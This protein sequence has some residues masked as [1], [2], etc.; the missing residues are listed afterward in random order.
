ML[1]LNLSQGDF[2][3]FISCLIE[4]VPFGR[5]F[6]HE[7]RNRDPSR[8]RRENARRRPPKTRTVNIPR[9]TLIWRR[10]SESRISKPDIESSDEDPRPGVTSR[11]REDL[12]S[13]PEGGRGGQRGE[14]RGDGV[15][16]A[17]GKFPLKDSQ[18]PPG[19]GRD[20]CR[21][22]CRPQGR[23]NLI[24]C[25]SFPVSLAP[26]R[27]L[28]LLPA[29]IPLLSLSFSLSLALF[30]LPIYHCVLPLPPPSAEPR[31]FFVDGRPAARF[32]LIAE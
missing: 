22:M 18:G 6:P 17:R 11:G 23:R 24:H 30:S 4:R 21:R 27:C 28:S 5:D 3:F 10:L 9:D 29:S 19:G 32:Q 1:R 14:P 25:P 31:R 15:P 7:D 16:F 26:S 13:P 2:F 20:E 8:R 12:Q